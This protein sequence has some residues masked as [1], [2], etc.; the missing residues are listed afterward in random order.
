[1]E[2]TH[3]SVNPGTRHMTDAWIA[4]A[5]KLTREGLFMAE[6][7][8]RNHTKFEFYTEHPGDK[9][10]FRVKSVEDGFYLFGEDG[11]AV[12]V[13]S[14]SDLSHGADMHDDEEGLMQAIQRAIAR[15]SLFGYGEN[16]GMMDDDEDDDEDYTE[17][18]E[19]HNGHEVV[20]PLTETQNTTQPSRTIQTRSR[21]ANTDSGAMISEAEH[22]RNTGNAARNAATTISE[23]QEGVE[24][25]ENIIIGASHDNLHKANLRGATVVMLNAPYQTLVLKTTSAA[26]VPVT[27]GDSNS[28]RHRRHRHHH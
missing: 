25:T 22:R 15:D 10:A 21:T 7:K 13:P 4:F 20:V 27:T 5:N 24:D 28:S 6:D 26:A 19:T 8:D 17:N 1:M 16:D 2:E 12:P 11:D 23:E 3:E 18:V 9:K 14:L